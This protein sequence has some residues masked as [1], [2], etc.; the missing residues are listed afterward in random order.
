M[1]FFPQVKHWAIGIVKRKIAWFQLESPKISLLLV[2]ENPRTQTQGTCNRARCAGQR[3][4][5]QYGAP[6]KD[7][8]DV[9]VWI[10]FDS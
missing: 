5:K 7:G 10:I 6:G 4:P 1:I 8:E 2:P 9:S 3:F